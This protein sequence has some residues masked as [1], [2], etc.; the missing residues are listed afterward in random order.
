MLLVIVAFRLSV[1]HGKCAC[2]VIASADLAKSTINLFYDVPGNHLTAAAVVETIYQCFGDQKVR[3]FMTGAS[4][5]TGWAI[6]QRLKDRY[7]YNVLCHSTDAGR[8]AYF[9]SQGFR[10]ASTLSEGSAYTNLWI[11]GKFDRAV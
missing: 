1:I 10:A 2:N 11:I 3:L 7:G 6:A 8:R 9:E 4:S 5:K